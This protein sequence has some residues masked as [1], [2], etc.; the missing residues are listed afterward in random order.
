[1][2]ESK[3]KD[4]QSAKN[5]LKSIYGHLL[6]PNINKAYHHKEIETY[7]MFEFILNELEKISENKRK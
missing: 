6:S 3:I 2:E 7:K 1:M 4:I 5:Q